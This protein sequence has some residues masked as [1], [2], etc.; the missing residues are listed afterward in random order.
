MIAGEAPNIRRLITLAETALASEAGEVDGFLTAVGNYITALEDWRAKIGDATAKDVDADIR[1]LLE[2]L[3]GVH[4]K[5]LSS[6]DRL[7]AGLVHEMGENKKKATAL[8]AYV[9]RLPQRITI[10]GR[11]KG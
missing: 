4:T 3:N 8:R 5:L 10:A 7:K 11:R 1:A 6:G 9:D 2:E